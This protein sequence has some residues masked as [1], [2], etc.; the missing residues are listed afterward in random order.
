VQKIAEHHLDNV[1]MKLAQLQ[2]MESVLAATV[3]KC[4]GDSSPACP[5]LEMLDAS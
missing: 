2:R 3:A 1:R 4:S 5:V